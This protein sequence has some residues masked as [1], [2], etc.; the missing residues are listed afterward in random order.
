MQLKS[1][2]ARAIPWPTFPHPLVIFYSEF[3]ALEVGSSCKATD[4]S[5]R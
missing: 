2:L 3:R 1:V 5:L 4:F